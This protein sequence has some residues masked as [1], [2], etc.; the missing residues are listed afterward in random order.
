MAL[1]MNK[2]KIVIIDNDT[3][4]QASVFN[5]IKNLGIMLKSQ[6]QSD[7]DESTHLIFPGVG[8]FP[9][10]INNFNKLNIKIFYLKTFLIKRNLF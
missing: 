5:A 10:F 8:S 4:N 2:N 9:N 6:E 7:F 3:D 1:F